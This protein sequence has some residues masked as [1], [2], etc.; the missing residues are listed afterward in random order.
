MSIAD[1]SRTCLASDDILDKI[2]YIET[3]E[4]AFG[5]ACQVGYV[6][7]QAGVL[8]A[9]TLADILGGTWIKVDFPESGLALFRSIVGEL[10]PKLGGAVTG[11]EDAM[12]RG[13]TGP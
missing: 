1:E 2:E 7:D 4:E 10:V 11:A 3:L 9:E 8:D 6:V 5:A 13:R 12:R